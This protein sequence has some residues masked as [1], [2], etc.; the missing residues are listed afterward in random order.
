MVGTSVVV[1]VDG[2]PEARDA[3]ALGQRIALATG[4][5]LHLITA[6]ADLLADVALIR[7]GLDINGMHE[8]LLESARSSVEANLKELFEA[9]EL[10]KVLT[11]RIGR[12]EH[13]L[14]EYGR[15]VDADLFVLGGRHHAAPASWFRRGTAHHILR[16]GECP[17]L[18]TGPHGP[19]VER[20]LVAVDISFAAEPT[21]NTARELAEILGVG[22]E[23]V[24]VIASPGVPGEWGTDVDPGALVEAGEEQ[25][26]RELWPL[27]PPGTPTSTLHGETVQSIQRAAEKGSSALLVVGAQGR[28]RIDRLLLGS[29]TEALLADLSSSL[30]IVPV[31][32]P[33]DR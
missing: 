1:G 4:R 24:H 13:V 26:S 22:L 27:L 14:V 5:S 20:V 28:G 17:L 16:V 18:I 2:T 8:A 23:A 19:E 31:R 25:V 15:E 30:A 3:A 33:S 21:I 9:D 10:A 29:T 7:L 11:V 6:A 12:P 32:P